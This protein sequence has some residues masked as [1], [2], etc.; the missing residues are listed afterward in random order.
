MLRLWRWRI[1]TRRLRIRRATSVYML[2]LQRHDW[3]ECQKSNIE[4]TGCICKSVLHAL[5]T[6]Y[7]YCSVRNSSSSERLESRSTQG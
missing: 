1:G 3:L 4:L 2:G 6:C 7:C 5:A